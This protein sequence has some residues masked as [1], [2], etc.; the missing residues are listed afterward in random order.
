V[1]LA[2]LP[3]GERALRHFLYLE[4]PEGMSLQDAAGFE[5]RAV[6]STAAMIDDD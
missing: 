3:F 2:L 4:R 6:G 1:Q 5:A